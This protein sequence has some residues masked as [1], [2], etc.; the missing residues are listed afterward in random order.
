MNLDK[1]EKRYNSKLFRFFDLLY[2]LLVLNIMTIII[3]LPIITFFP[4]IVAMVSTLKYDMSE[5]GIFKPYFRNFKKYFWKSFW[6]GLALLICFVAGAYAYYFWI[7]VETNHAFMKII[8]QIGIV[9]ISICVL[10]LVLLVSHLPQLICIFKDLPN[11][12]IFKVSFYISFRYFLTTLIMLIVNLVAY[13]SLVIILTLIFASKKIDEETGKT[14][15]AVHSSVRIM[16]VIWT[17]IGISLPKYLGL[18]FTKPLY[19]KLEKID[20]EKINQQIEEDINN[21]K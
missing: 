8:I 10:I 5:T 21:E 7:N 19:Y 14:V 16:L 15:L 2:R 6:M 20:M 1:N 13:G 11:F 3:S 9:V 17:M 12:Q 18:R 4:A